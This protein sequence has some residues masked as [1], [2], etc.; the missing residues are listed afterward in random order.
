MDADVLVTFH[1]GSRV[2]VLAHNSRDPA[3]R[4][5]TDRSKGIYSSGVG[6]KARYLYQAVPTAEVFGP[7]WN[8]AAAYTENVLEL[9]PKKN[10]KGL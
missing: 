5:C 2:E 4:A 10:C 9:C 8:S 1:A 6:P 7:V 3:W